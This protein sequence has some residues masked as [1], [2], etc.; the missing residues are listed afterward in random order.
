MT[1]QHR[2]IDGSPIDLPVGKVVCVGRNYAEHAHELGNEVPEA[3]IFFIKPASSLV[4][5]A[6]SFSI[7]TDQGEV[8]HEIEMALLVG[9]RLKNA[10]AT[11]AQ[12]GMAGF[13]VGL[14]LTLR[15]LQDAL[16]KQGHP[17]ERAKA[18]DGA[19]PMSSFIDA[20]GVSWKQPI[21]ISLEV[22]GELRQR[23][24]TTQMLFPAFQLVAQM[25]HVFTLEPGDIVLTGTPSGVAALHP[26]DQLLAKFGN[27]LTVKSEV[28][29]AP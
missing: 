20:R 6:P 1:Y 24:N 22:N 4:A 7:P 28:F 14:D 12:W 27:A 17:W 11:S 9:E 5:M 21:E 13:G 19:C 25:S 18:F 16:K 23:G 29:A 15:D 10:D 26:D 3:P 2:W 8:H